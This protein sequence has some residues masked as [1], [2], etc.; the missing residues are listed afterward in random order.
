MPA[1]LREPKALT[2]RNFVGTVMLSVFPGHRRY[3]HIAA[4]RCDPVN[5]PLL[6]RNG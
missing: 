6:V 2:G 4:L 1:V 5:P 3:A